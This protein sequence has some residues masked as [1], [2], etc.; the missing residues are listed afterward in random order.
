MVKVKVL[1]HGITS[2]R[3]CVSTTLWWK[4]KSDFF[5]CCSS[6]FLVSTTLWWKLKASLLLTKHLLRDV[7]T[8]LWWKLK[9]LLRYLDVYKA[10]RFNHPMVKVKVFK[11]I[12]SI[13]CCS[14]NHP[15]VKVKVFLQ[16]FLLQSYI[17]STTLWWKLKMSSLN[18]SDNDKQRFNHPMVK[19]KGVYWITK[20]IRICRLFQNIKL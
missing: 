9:E 15:M 4:L 13:A 3:L 17:V 19:V 10:E 16:G 12:S 2:L 8:T 18:F 20:K 7:S 5:I 1:T 14:F 6:S 11:A